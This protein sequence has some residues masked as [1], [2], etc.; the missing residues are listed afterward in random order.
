MKS[1]I[2]AAIVLAVCAAA[3]A[4]QTRRYFT[5]PIRGPIH[6]PECRHGFWHPPIWNRPIITRG[7]SP[8]LPPFRATV[9]LAPFRL[10]PSST[11]SHTYDPAAAAVPVGDPQLIV[12]PYVDQTGFEHLGSIGHSAT[13]DSKNGNGKSHS[14]R[15]PKPRVSVDQPN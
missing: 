3:H 15:S 13:L 7:I 4:G 10:G 14:D 12:N 6:L 1:A 11:T 5:P 8:S 9:P 2:T